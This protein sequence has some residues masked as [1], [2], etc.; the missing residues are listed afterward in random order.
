MRWSPHALEG[1]MVQ[2]IDPTAAEM[3]IAAPEFVVPDEPA[4]EVHMR[5]YFDGSTGSRMLIRV[6]IEETATERVVVTVYETSKLRK[7]QGLTP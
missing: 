7:Y 6:V 1:L 2:R 4:R 3:A 5:R